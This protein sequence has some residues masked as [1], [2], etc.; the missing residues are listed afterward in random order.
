VDVVAVPVV[1]R[2]PVTNS[3]WNNPAKAID[4]TYNWSG[5]YLGVTAGGGMHGTTV[6]DKNGR[7]ADGSLSFSK[8]FT[9]VGGTVGYSYQFGAGLVGIE[10]DL[11]WSNFDSS[12][13][14]PDWVSFHSTKSDWYST[15]RGRVGLAVDRVLI[16]ATGGVAF[17]DR[18]VTGTDTLNVIDPTCRNCF[19][20]KE[21]SV[22]LVGGVGAE[23]AFSGPWSMK[24]EYL[25]IATPTARAR[26]Q[27]E[28]DRNLSPI[29]G[30]GFHAGGPSRSELPLR[31]LIPFRN[32][33]IEGPGMVR[34]LHP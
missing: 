26:P 6:D 34:G 21:T 17:V 2:P 25:Y 16:Y 20:I 30:D 4:P 5:F 15:V 7:L 10:A 11:N 29:C 33:G 1:L 19:S 32:S 9:T 14:D 31:R 12:L 3:A 13:T 22:G 24:A 23:Y 27:S 18:K 28:Q 8:A